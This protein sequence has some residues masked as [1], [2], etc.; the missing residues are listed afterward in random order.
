MPDIVILTGLRPE[1]ENNL[2][3]IHSPE[4]L[5]VTSGAVI[6][7]FIPLRQSFFTGIDTVHLVRKSG[8]F[9]KRI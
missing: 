8:A 5:I 7:D 4:A 6:Q 3:A 1:I 2:S 9:I